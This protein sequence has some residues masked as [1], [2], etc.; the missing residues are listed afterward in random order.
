MKNE[1]T[2][3]LLKAAMNIEI[4]LLSASQKAKR[5]SQKEEM[6]RDALGVRLKT[7]KSDSAI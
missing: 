6:F 1:R 2:K 5:L 3:K 4:A 7:K